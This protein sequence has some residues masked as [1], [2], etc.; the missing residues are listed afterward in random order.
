MALKSRLL[1][2]AVALPL[3][4]GL[5]F[6]PA[7]GFDIR[8]TD[9]TP[10]STPVDTSTTT[11]DLND[12]GAHELAA[13]GEIVIDGSP[14][15]NQ[16]A[17]VLINSTGQN[18]V[19]KGDITIRDKDDDGE[20]STVALTDAVGVKISVDL[21]SSAGL[22]LGDGMNIIID[23]S[24]PAGIDTDEDGFAD[25]DRDE[26][27]I[28]EGSQALDGVHTRIGLWIA[29]TSDA[30]S[31]M[32]G[33]IIGEE[34]SFIRIDGNGARGVVVDHVIDNDFDLST[35]IHNGSVGGILGDDAI[36]VDINENITGYY[37]QRGDVDV[38]GED[39]IG[40]DIG[41]NIND[42]VMIDAQINATGYSTF[43]STSDGAPDHGRDESDLDATA[44]ARNAGERR[45]GGAAVNITGNVT[46]G[47]IIGGKANRAVTP[48]EEA[49]L[50]DINDAATDDDGDRV[51]ISPDGLNERTLPVHFDAN[52]PQHFTG[53]TGVR[54]TSYGEADD[55]ATLKITGNVGDLTNGGA[56]ETLLD[57]THDDEQGDEDTD[58]YS[59]GTAGLQKFYYSHGFMN[60]A[61]IAADGLYDGFKADAV[62]FD[63]NATVRGGFY[64][65]GTISAK[66][67]NA[68][69]TAVEFDDVNLTDGLRSDGSVFLN[70]GF[71]DV[72]VSTHQGADANKTKSSDTATA[73]LLTGDALF[74]V[75][76]TPTFLNRGFIDAEARFF[77][78]DGDE[79]SEGGEGA[80]AFDAMNVNANLNLTQELLKADA[81]LGLGGSPTANSAANP[82]RGGGDTDID[83]R[84]DE[85]DDGN[86]QGDGVIDTRD[87]AAPRMVGDVK[88]GIG[89]NVF[90]VKAG[91][92]SGDISFGG[93]TDELTLSNEIADDEDDDYTAPLTEVTGRLSKS[94]GNLDISIGD[95]SVLHLEGQ[96]GDDDTETEGLT[97][98]DLT[99]TGE[100]GL[101]ITVDKSQ[102][103][104]EVLDVTNL[105]FS[106]DSK[107]TPALTSL[108]AAGET[109][110]VKL[111]SYNALTKNNAIGTYL[112]D[113]T[114]FIY[115]VSLRDESNA[116][117][118]DFSVKSADDLGLNQT[119]AAALNAVIAHF[120]DDGSREQRLTAFDNGDDF[121]AAYSQL[122]P[123]YG[124]GTAQQLAVLSEAAT[125][126]VSQHLQLVAAGG[127]RG[128]DGW[129]QQFGDH[130]KQDGTADNG[131]VSGT[132]YG[133][134]FG[135]D[136]PAGPVDALGF[137]T[138]MNFT[139][140][141]EKTTSLNEVN[142]DGF[143]FGTYLADRFGPLRAEANAAY[144]LHD[145]ES[146]RNVRFDGLFD[147]MRASWSA[148]STSASARL[149]YPIL[150]DLHVLR[151]EGG[152]DYF[153]LVHDD[154]S[155]TEFY[156]RGYSMAVKG[157]ESEKLAQFIGLRGGYR[158]GGG[159]PVSIVWQPSYYLGWR[160][161]ADETPYRATANF[162]GTAESFTLENFV[163]TE[164]AIELGLGVAA[165]NDYFA[166]EFNYRGQFADGVE[167]HGGGVSIRLLF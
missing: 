80:I 167:T 104:D 119:E 59:R 53:N 144:G 118:A 18:V 1:T 61:T 115:D 134:A 29:G 126:A 135:Y 154:Y 46:G 100:A 136:F 54:L 114:P 133:L 125:G 26:D 94:S 50:A 108:F 166:F 25:N 35:A 65:I 42:G 73:I 89:N 48:A 31:V 9:D 110:T 78:S 163:E 164:D 47:L 16:D 137:Y 105:S 155:E 11:G 12:D 36:G 122:F 149:A 139:S 4:T 70:E 132:S 99:L 130:R 40:I 128:G 158:S 69:A 123:H 88:F 64:T 74:N 38:R 102:L 107:L 23:E 93:G 84:G 17:A 90:T 131:T 32:A 41:A 79:D 101:K 152:V 62:L 67:N 124:D 5:A 117:F 87:V 33:P 111:I 27:G 34:G 151:V 7:Q 52:R 121:R 66:A 2:T 57:L 148:V 146:T 20:A 112:A 162:V 22:R 49:E 147:Q 138:Q 91:T 116:I 19:I 44:A 55:T 97:V 120:N 129:L 150:Q 3:L 77:D 21:P 8:D 75:T 58:I 82:Y 127:R 113:E 81:L 98:Q 72:E 92:V 10:R 106:D 56:I 153:K 156:G 142:G 43:S 13:S 96:E 28:L 157:G 63:G 165:H 103:S 76:G 68:D 145:L 37:R 140:V 51:D 83:R 39:S 14:Q 24:G 161:T 141:N 71:I 109:E 30:S 86:P 60:R 6:G 45:R 15:G 85:D 159:D 95:R 160:G 143:T